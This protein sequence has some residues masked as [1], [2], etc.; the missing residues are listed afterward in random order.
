MHRWPTRAALLMLLKPAPLLA[1]GTDCDR[2]A[3]L[4]AIPRIEGAA[5]PYAIHDPAAAVAA[6]DAARRAQ[7]DEPFFTVLLARARLAADPEDPAPVEL[8][9][10]VVEE[11]PPLA[12][13]ELGRLYESG[14]A[15]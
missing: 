7:P 11:I 6:C 9:S 4:P 12:A 2:L 14:L 13:S 10:D 3:G 8:L 1:Q 15:G 5:G